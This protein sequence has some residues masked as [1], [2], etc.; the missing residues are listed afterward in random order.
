MPKSGIPHPAQTSL[1][2][3][4]QRFLLSSPLL[5]DRLNRTGVH[6]MPYRTHAARGSSFGLGSV[7]RCACSSI[8]LQE[9]QVFTFTNCKKLFLFSGYVL[10][11]DFFCHVQLPNNKRH[12]WNEVGHIATL[13]PFTRELTYSLSLASFHRR[14]FPLTKNACT[15]TPKA[16]VVSSSKKPSVTGCPLRE[17]EGPWLCVTGFPRFCHCHDL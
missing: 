14:A 3:L 17:K 2:N 9:A 16:G 5:S 11:S 1:R 10:S 6:R 8:Q 4:I 13:L 12:R 7:L 15:S